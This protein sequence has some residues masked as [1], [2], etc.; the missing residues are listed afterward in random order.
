MIKSAIDTEYHLPVI[1]GYTGIGVIIPASI[2]TF[3][4]K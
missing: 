3:A 1:T 4:D 2:L